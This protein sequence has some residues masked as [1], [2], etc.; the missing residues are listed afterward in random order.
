MSTDHTDVVTD[1]RRPRLGL[2]P[3][4]TALRVENRSRRWRADVNVRFSP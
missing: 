2:A 3:G 4:G 1:H